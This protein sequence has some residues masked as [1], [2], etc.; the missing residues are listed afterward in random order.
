MNKNYEVNREDVGLIIIDIQDSLAKSVVNE[1]EMKEETKKLIQAAKIL[2][3]PIAF[4]TQYKKG[5]GDT[6]QE[7]RDLAP[8]APS[9]DKVHFGI[10]GEEGIKEA[11]EKMGKKQFI[12]VGME[13]HICVLSS[14][15]DLLGEGYE[16]FVP[17]GAVGSRDQRNIDNALT[18][19]LKMGAVVTNTES[20]LFQ[21]CVKST[22]PEFKEIQNLIK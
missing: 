11:I 6:N 4:T 2:D 22:C 8:D 3:L 1:K 17:L 16:V 21:L 7:L 9:F 12:V 10:F 15:I 13:T 20:I 18:L 19:M 14:V 5:L